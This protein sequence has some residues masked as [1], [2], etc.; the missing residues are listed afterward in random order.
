MRS[1]AGTD[2]VM[3]V[4][5]ALTARR[6]DDPEA[7]TPGSHIWVNEKRAWVVIDDGLPQY[8]AGN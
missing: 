7:L 1:W 5:T 4:M 8:F 3:I 2:Q 6:I